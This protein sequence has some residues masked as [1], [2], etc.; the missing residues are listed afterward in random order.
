MEEVVLVDGEDNEIGTA[1]KI[2]AH[3]KGLLHRA[4]SIFIFN[5]KGELLIQKRADDKYHSG[6]LWSNTCCSHPRPG[7]S[8]EEAAKRRLD[9]EMGIEIPL[10]RVFAFT[11]RVDLENG[12][13]EH[14]YDHV[15]VGEFNG[16]PDID[17]SEATD[18][19]WI[20]VEELKKDIVEA[21]ERYT[22]WLKEPLNRII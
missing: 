16:E 5:S 10:R 18:W 20:N 8:L 7:E 12:L 15:F 9:E 6:G 13:S 19:K 22:Y 4:F 21:P 17:V 11:Y 3:K 1:E 2:E 14:E